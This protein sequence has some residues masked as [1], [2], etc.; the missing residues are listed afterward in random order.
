MNI[1]QQNN[2]IIMILKSVKK[3][4]KLL[5]AIQTSVHAVLQGAHTGVKNRGTHHVVV[6]D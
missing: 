5:K 3:D 4:F 6:F 2:I 1:L